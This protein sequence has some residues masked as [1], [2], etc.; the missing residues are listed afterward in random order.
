MTQTR[1]LQEKQILD[2]Y[3]QGKNYEFGNL[4]S[5]V[6]YLRIA[7]RTQLGNSYVLRFT[8]QDYPNVKPNVYVEC[9]LLDRR[10]NPMNSASRSNH[11][12]QPL[13]GRWTQICHY[14]PDAWQPKLTL[15][16][17]YVRCLVW[18]NMYEQSKR[19]GHDIDHYL[20]HMDENFRY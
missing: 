18:L 10:G 19:T 9:M 2:Y 1:Y 6:P 16:L 5:S 14:H 11:T 15:W 3:M 20:G 12:L 8:L 13:N 17:V 4:N 7:A